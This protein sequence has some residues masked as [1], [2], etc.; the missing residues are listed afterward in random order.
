MQVQERLQH[1]LLDIF[2][3]ASNI[4]CFK[5]PEWQWD[6]GGPPALTLEKQCC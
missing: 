6:F 2:L 3:I 1:V 4:A 5:F